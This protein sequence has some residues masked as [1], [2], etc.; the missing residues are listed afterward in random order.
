VIFN[1]A[2]TSLETKRPLLPHDVVERLPV[3][4]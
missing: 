2:G 1:F 4:A 3:I